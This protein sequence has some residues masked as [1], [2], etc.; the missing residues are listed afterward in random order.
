MQPT[1]DTDTEDSFATALVNV[2]RQLPDQYLDELDN[3]SISV[4]SRS[5]LG[6]EVNGVC[7]W[8]KDGS[9]RIEFNP[10]LPRSIWRDTILHEIAHALVRDEVDEHGE[11]WKNV[12]VE[13]GAVPR[14]CSPEG[15]VYPVWR[16]ACDNSHCGEMNEIPALDG[17]EIPPTLDDLI[18][19]GCD[20][21]W[22]VPGLAE[23]MPQFI[24]RPGTPTIPEA[25]YGRIRVLGPS[26]MREIALEE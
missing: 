2:V 22:E 1:H 13:L 17:P 10:Y 18:E 26:G 21:C 15:P 24:Y 8:L 12:A 5:H 7:W 23:D 4:R 25:E 9:A 11:G 3:Y 19:R 14:P 6:P 20:G 16:F